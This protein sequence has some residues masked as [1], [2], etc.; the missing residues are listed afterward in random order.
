M[1]EL[2][3]AG[4]ILGLYSGFSPGPL[5]VL[6]ISQT[7]THGY[8]EGVKVAL[9]PVITDLPII[10]ISI[11]LLSVVSGYNFIIGS[12]SILGGLYVLYLAYGSI[13]TKGL[14]S[15][16]DIEEPKSLKK[17]IIVNLLNPSPYLFWI[18]V[19]GPILITAYSRD[20]ASP[21]LFIT[22]FYTF[23]VGSK[24]VL[25]YATGKSRD[26]LIGTSYVY[27]MRILGVFLIIFAL[28]LINEGI[29]L[30]F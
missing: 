4:I 3:I 30:I 29:Q 2:L 8:R 9:V 14:T 22:G 11:V 18:T 23:L 1:V 15:N 17:G 16:F 7:L 10:L 12:I 27:I 25:A 24:I 19:G 28:Y 20:I 26:F 5:L 13:N 21:L 6:V